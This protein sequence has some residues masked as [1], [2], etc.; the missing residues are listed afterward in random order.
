MGVLIFLSQINM[1]PDRQNNSDVN[2]SRD[3]R[4]HPLLLVSAR[5]LACTGT[6]VCVKEEVNGPSLYNV[7]HKCISFIIEA[8]SNACIDCFLLHTNVFGT[9]M[10][11]ILQNIER[12]K[13]VITL[14]LS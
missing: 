3:V 2:M 11:L 9:M 12:K 1:R 14:A 6:C 5:T 10:T 7:R 13:N 8:I 4:L